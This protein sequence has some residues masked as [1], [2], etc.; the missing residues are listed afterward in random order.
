MVGCAR[1]CLGEGRGRPGFWVADEGFRGARPRH[2][3]LPT[4]AARQLQAAGEPGARASAALRNPHANRDAV[5]PGL[6]APLSHRLPARRSV[7]NSDQWRIA[8]RRA[9]S[10]GARLRGPVRGLWGAPDG[11]KRRSWVLGCVEQCAGRAARSQGAG[12]PAPADV[13]LLAWA[14]A[15]AACL[16][17][18]SHASQRCGPAAAADEASSVTWE[19]DTPARGCWGPL[20]RPTA[21]G[22]QGDERGAEIVWCRALIGTRGGQTEGC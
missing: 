14:P 13:D 7:A 5:R 2:A 19:A 4:H 20:G 15:H 9:A 18:P 1:K 8:R 6:P 22:V 11:A 3:R 17:R 21:Q 16:L 12:R 10:S